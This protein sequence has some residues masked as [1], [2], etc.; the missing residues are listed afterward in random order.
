MNNTYQNNTYQ[1]D[2]YVN[3][4]YQNDTY[5]NN[6]YQNETSQNDTYV[7]NTYSNSSTSIAY[8]NETFQNMTYL[9]ETTGNDYENVN[10]INSLE[11][12]SDSGFSFPLL[13]IVFLILLGTLVLIQTLAFR[14]RPETP[15]TFIDPHDHTS[16]FNEDTIVQEES[17][18]E[19]STDVEEE[20]IEESDAEIESPPL[21]SKGTVDES[22]FEWLEWPAGSGINHYRKAESQDTWEIWQ[23]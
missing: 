2:T 18:Q 23:S 11:Q 5:V 7:N 8:E 6:T 16:I 17:N 14:R 21:D 19:S 13:E 22:G 20:I 10:P 3:T 1:N 9:N 12:V 4:T 15:S